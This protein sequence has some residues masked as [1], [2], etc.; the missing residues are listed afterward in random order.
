MG[1]N[2][3][4]LNYIKTLTEFTTEHCS[5]HNCPAK[6]FNEKEDYICSGIGNRGSICCIIL[7]TYISTNIK[8]FNEII[9]LINEAYKE[10]YNIGLLETVYIT[11]SIKCFV[12]GCSYKVSHTMLE[13]CAV[14]TQSEFYNNNFTK[15]IFLGDSKD[16]LMYLNVPSYHHLGCPYNIFVD[17]N[18]KN[19]FLKLL[20][21]VL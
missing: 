9:N 4:Y 13:K 6:L 19:T 18:E 3:K 16:L 1:T 11:P 8:L 20:F 14:K 2:K 21:K 12:D 15:I 17:D 10:K 5:C 7:P